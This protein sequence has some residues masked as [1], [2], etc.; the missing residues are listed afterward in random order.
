MSVAIIN[1]AS[2]A[3]NNG[4]WSGSIAVVTDGSDATWDEP[5]VAGTILYN[6]VPGQVPVTAAV[7]NSIKVKGRGLATSAASATFLARVDLGGNTTSQGGFGP[8][9]PVGNWDSGAMARPGGG[10][11]VAADIDSITFGGFGNWGGGPPDPPDLVEIWLEVDFTPR[12][13]GFSFIL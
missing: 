12:A 3:F 4:G 2:V 5:T 1:P 11:W 6:P 8:L 7:I 9:D 13:A 10:S